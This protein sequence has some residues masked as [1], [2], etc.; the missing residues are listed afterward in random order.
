MARIRTIKPEFPQ[1]ERMGKVSRDARLL[2]IMLWTIADDAGRARGNSRVLASLLY[3]YD[4][5][6]RALL[7][8]WL[9]ELEDTGSIRRYIVDGSTYLE[10]CNWL[11]HQKIDKPSGPKCPGFD[12]GSPIP[13]E[14]SPPDQDRDQYHDLDHDHDRD[15]SLSAAPTARTG[16]TGNDLEK[17]AADLGI[18]PADVQRVFE[19]WRA[20][21]S[22]PLAKL[23]A[24]RRKL[25]RLRLRD[26]TADALCTAISGYLNSPHH[27]GQNDRATTYDDIGLF[28]RD[29]AHVDAGLRFAAAPPR[30][31]QSA[32]TRRNVAAV[33]DWVP[34]EMRGASHAAS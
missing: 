18:D 2:F 17:L 23:D 6:A 15:R 8:G 30:A 25:I 19:H 31:D 10:I 27:C 14:V 22:H 4:D 24:K 3:P 32:L 12:E 20:A 1:S 7:P 33:A 34:P 13:R 11:K 9:D 29:S 26:Y 5:D 16:S 21:W 28:L